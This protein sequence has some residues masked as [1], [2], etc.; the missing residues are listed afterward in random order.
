TCQEAC[1]RGIVINTIQCGNDADCTKYWK[2]ICKKAEGSFAQISQSGGVVTIA[3]PF[4]KELAK[5]NSE[6]TSRTVV[7]GAAPPRATAM[8][9]LDGAK[10][11]PTSE[12]AA[13][14]S[15]AGR[16][17]QGGGGGGGRMDAR[18]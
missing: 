15:F 10:K 6:M 1:K 14:A 3:T 16:S 8:K 17:A 2:D 11:L 12:A 5:I 13:R 9:R 4:D 18:Q 7:Y